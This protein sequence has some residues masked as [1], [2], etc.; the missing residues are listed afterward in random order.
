MQTRTVPERCSSELQQ[1]VSRC[2][3]AADRGDHEETQDA[4][5]TNLGLGEAQEEEVVRGETAGNSQE[6]TAAEG[7]WPV[8]GHMITVLIPDWLQAHHRDLR[9]HHGRQHLRGAGPL[10]PRGR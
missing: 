6:E 1:T 2:S 3:D 8:A 4:G 9:Q 5:Q 7:D 10:P